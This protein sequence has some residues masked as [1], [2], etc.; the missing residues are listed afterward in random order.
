VS[1]R[2]CV[3]MESPMEDA[4]VE[5]IVTVTFAPQKRA[6][7]ARSR[8]I[9]FVSTCPACGLQRSQNGYTRR[10]I[11]RLLETNHTIDAYCVPCDVLW[12]ISFDERLVMT[13]LIAAH[14]DFAP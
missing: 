10:A 9:T 8:S 2:G 13:R 6:D 11:T 14:Q 4:Q 1:V 5:T 7:R 12:P 3:D